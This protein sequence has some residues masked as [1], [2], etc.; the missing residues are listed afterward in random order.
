M[1]NSHGV[2]R[3]LIPPCMLCPT[4]VP[5]SQRRLLE[6]PFGAFANPNSAGCSS[7]GGQTGQSHPGT[8]RIQFFQI[9]C[10]GRC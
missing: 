6:E 4:V 5:V 10:D 2:L 8:H 1:C 7:R 3:V 9:G